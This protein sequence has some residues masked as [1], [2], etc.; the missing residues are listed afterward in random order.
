L[1]L[2]FKIINYKL[3]QLPILPLF[4]SQKT[5]KKPANHVLHKMKAELLQGKYL[6]SD[7]A[8]QRCTRTPTAM[9]SDRGL[10]LESCGCWRSGDLKMLFGYAG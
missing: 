2:L 10:D 3:W 4:L 9:Q 5:Y 7:G 1:I 8:N 6:F